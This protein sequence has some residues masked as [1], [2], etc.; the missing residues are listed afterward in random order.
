MLC[1]V[2][3]AGNLVG[4]HL[5]SLW[6]HMM[7]WKRSI[8][9]MDKFLLGGKYPWWSQQRQG[10]GLRRCGK[11][12]GLGISLPH[13]LYTFSF[14][15]INCFKCVLWCFVCSAE[16]HQV[17][18][19]GHHIMVCYADACQNYVF[20]SLKSLKF[21]SHFNN[22]SIYFACGAI[23]CC[24]SGSFFVISLLN[25]HQLNHE[26]WEYLYIVWIFIIMRVFPGVLFI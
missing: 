25:D 6:I 12:L 5:C 26:A 11:S 1:L 10:K 15:L 13:I 9:W 17:M 20:D 21:C 23:F 8:A 16:D 24:L 19:G 2:L 22:H 18:E 14:V 7:Q 4:L 3:Y